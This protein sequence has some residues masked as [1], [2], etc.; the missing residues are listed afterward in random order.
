[1]RRHERTE[2]KQ[3][4]KVQG[5]HLAATP[6]PFFSLSSVHSVSLW[7]VFPS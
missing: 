5:V 4:G 2:K 1:M 6:L 7:F 3:S